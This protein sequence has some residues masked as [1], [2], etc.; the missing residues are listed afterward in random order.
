MRRL[1]YYLYE[2]HLLQQVLD[3]PVPQHV[4]I[5]LDGNRRYAQQRGL[6]ESRDIYN[7]GA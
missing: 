4:G 6:T 1:L 3:L 7:L 2:R 5:I